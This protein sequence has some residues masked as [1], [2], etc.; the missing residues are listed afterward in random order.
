MTLSH[1][2]GGRPATSSRRISISGSAAS[3]SVTA[4]ANASR[5]TARAPPAGTLWASAQRMISESSARISRCST[6]TALVSESSERNE[7]EQ[8]SS[9]Q[10]SVLWASV[11][12][13]GRISCS[14]TGT[15]A[16]AICQAASEPASPPPITWMGAGEEFCRS[17]I[18]LSRTSRSG[19]ERRPSFRSLLGLVARDRRRRIPPMIDYC[20]I[21]AQFAMLV[22]VFGRAGRTEQA[23]GKRP[24]SG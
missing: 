21:I 13:K 1:C 7:L 19:R 3:A 15:P 22:D 2:A 18:R 11:A 12:R 6:P 16:R 9:A 4:A 14:T 17:V 24:L 23:I 20:R 10:K 8:T 5:S